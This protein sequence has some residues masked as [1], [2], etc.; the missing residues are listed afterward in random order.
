VKLI[1]AILRDQ[2]EDSVMKM[3]TQEGLRV[4]SIAS[5]G[6]IFKHGMTT[7]IIGVEDA[8]LD[9]ALSLLRSTCKK[10]EGEKKCGTLFVL[11]IE[12][13]YRF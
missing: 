8:E 1:L 6:G 5:T 9:K 2:A 3:L 11:K 12:D 13:S 10:V 4:T 7:L